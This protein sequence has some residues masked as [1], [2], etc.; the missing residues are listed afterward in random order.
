MRAMVAGVSSS[1]ISGIPARRLVEEKP[2]SREGPS[3]SPGKRA[4]LFSVR[5]FPRRERM[6]AK[7]SFD[8]SG[9]LSHDLCV[10][11]VPVS[12]FARSGPRF[13]IGALVESGPRSRVKSSPTS[14]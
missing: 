1:S 2:R 10:P 5:F 8:R 6:N 4:S 12:T 7:R 11:R 9:Q 13:P 14:P 3:R